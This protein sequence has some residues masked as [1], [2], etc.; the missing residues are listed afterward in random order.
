MT[1]IGIELDKQSVNGRTYRRAA[2]YIDSPKPERTKALLASAVAI[3]LFIGS[4][5]ALNATDVPDT[6]PTMNITQVT[7]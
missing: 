7:R 6:K 3:A 1:R 5:F 4:V 2:L